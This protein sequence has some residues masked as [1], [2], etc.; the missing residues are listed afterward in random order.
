MGVETRGDGNG[1]ELDAEILCQALRI[2]LAAFG[3]I[4]AGHRDAQNVFFA[5]GVDGDGRYNSGVNAAAEADDGLAEIAFADVVPRAG[6]NGLV[7]V[8]DFFFCLR[9]DV[10]FARDRVE[11]DNIFLE[12]FGLRCDMAVGGE[13]HAGAVENERIVA[14]DLVNVNDRAGM[15]LGDGAKNF[16]TQGALVDGVGRGGDIQQ[17]AGSLLD[18]L[19]NGVARV[20]WL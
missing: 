20:T 4:R 10:A 6:D 1:K 15:L 13:S 11:Q 5:E 16:Y 7:G 17:D 14:A 9:V 3:G 18:Q 2:G 12:G 8:G 19:S